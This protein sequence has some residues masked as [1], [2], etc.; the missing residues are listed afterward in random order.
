[1]IVVDINKHLTRNYTD[2]IVSATHY[3]RVTENHPTWITQHKRSIKT[4]ACEWKL[5]ELTNPMIYNYSSNHK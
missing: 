4:N 2:F 3:V 5:S 1:M